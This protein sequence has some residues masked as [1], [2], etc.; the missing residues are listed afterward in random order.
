MA[1]D[2]CPISS[3]PLDS[4]VTSSSP[5]AILLAIL[6]KSERG[7][8]MSFVSITTKVDAT[9]TAKVPSPIMIFLEDT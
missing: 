3:L 7:F 6:V 2:N 9:T 8:A 4:I 5:S 1:P